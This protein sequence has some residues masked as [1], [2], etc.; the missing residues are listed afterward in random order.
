MRSGDWR[1][2]WS[3]RSTVAVLGGGSN[4]PAQHGLRLFRVAGVLPL[5]KRS[6]FAWRRANPVGALRL[7]ASDPR[8]LGLSAAMFL[9][10]LSHAVF[11]AVYVLHAG[12]RFGWGEATVGL[13]LA[14]FGLCMAV[15]QGALVRPVIAR[16]GERR[17]LL[18]GMAFGISGFLMMGLA[19]TA[20]WFWASSPVMALWG[21]IGPAAQSLTTRLVQPN[22]QGQLQGAGSSLMGVA[23]LIGPTLFTGS[24]YLGIDP[25]RGALLPGAPY[26]VAA[27][28]LA[29]AFVVAA[30]V[31]SD[32]L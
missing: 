19:S 26:L 28:L 7:L 9:F 4:E 8:L 25:T 23:S 5:E 10:N 14:V 31:T 32:K 18:S 11:P 3:H 20:P 2:A 6:P 15:V 12:Y 16:F 1:V 17:A 22:E 29:C 13:G 24:F 21:L 27:T 30:R